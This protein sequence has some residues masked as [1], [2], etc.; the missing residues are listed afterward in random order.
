V[1]FDGELN[2]LENRKKDILNKLQDLTKKM[3]G[4]KKPEEVKEAENRKSSLVSSRRNLL[5][6]IRD[7]NK[8]MEDIRSQITGFDDQ[9]PD[10]Y[11]KSKVLPQDEQELDFLIGGWD[12]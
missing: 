11:K 4:L 9:R 10:K 5:V 3:K 6:E 12:E 7:L 1:K 8:T 2:K